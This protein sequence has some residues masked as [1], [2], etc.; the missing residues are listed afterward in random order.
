[1]KRFG[2]S[3]ERFNPDQFNL[4]NVAEEQ[5]AE[6]ATNTS[7]YFRRYCGSIA[8]RL[9]SPERSKTLSMPANES[10]WLNDH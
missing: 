1:M 8:L 10:S 6:D 5:A 3:S 7:L 2:K 9:S 4:F